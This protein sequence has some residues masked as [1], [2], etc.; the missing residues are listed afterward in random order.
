MRASRVKRQEATEKRPRDLCYPTLP[1]SPP[2]LCWLSEISGRGCLSSGSRS[3]SST[4]WSPTASVQRQGTG[5]WPG[6][7]WSARTGGAGP[8]HWRPKGPEPRHIRTAA[9]NTGPSKWLKQTSLTLPLSVWL[10]RADPGCCL[11]S[12]R[13]P[14]AASLHRST[15]IPW[16]QPSL[17]DPPTFPR[18]G[19]GKGPWGHSDVHHHSRPCLQWGLDSGPGTAPG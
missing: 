13:A 15:P 1:I 16:V 11:F 14:R 4:R 8:S 18:G 17:G 12:A 6:V 7:P 10:V 2:A 9:Q 5:P 19:G 3:M